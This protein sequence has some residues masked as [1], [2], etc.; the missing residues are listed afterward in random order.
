MDVYHTNIGHE[1]C[2]IVDT[3]WQ[4]E[5]GKIMITPLPGVAGTKP[6]SATWPFPG[7]SAQIHDSQGKGVETGGGPL[8]LTHPWPAM[9]RG[10]YGDPERF[11]KTS[12]TAGTTGSIPPATARAATKTASMADGPG[13][14]RAQCRRPSAGDDGGREPARRS[15]KGG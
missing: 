14:R 5:T 9:L 6:G 8:A 3:W 4:T 2:P 11:V 1:R 7:I 10:I 13:G 12:F 15:S